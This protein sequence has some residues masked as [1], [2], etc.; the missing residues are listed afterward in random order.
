MVEILDED[1]D[2]MEAPKP[3][4]VTPRNKRAKKMKEPLPDEFL[5]RSKRHADRSGGFKGKSVVEILN[6]KPLAIIPATSA[7]A[8]HLNRDIVEGIATGFLQIHPRDVSDA[9][10]KMDVDDDMD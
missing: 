6:P 3:D 10:I 5:R 8:P 7:P 1:D 4:H 2:V 9:L